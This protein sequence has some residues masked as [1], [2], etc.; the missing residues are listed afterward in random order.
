MLTK[1]ILECKQIKAKKRKSYKSDDKCDCHS[2]D[3]QLG[4]KFSM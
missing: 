1:V 2:L 4:L 3:V